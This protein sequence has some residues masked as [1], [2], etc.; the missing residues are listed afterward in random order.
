M[1]DAGFPNHPLLPCAVAYPA[2]LFYITVTVDSTPTRRRKCTVPIRIEGE[3]MSSFELGPAPYV[4]GLPLEALML[5]N[6]AKR[7]GIHAMLRAVGVLYN[8]IAF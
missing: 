6:L 8:S 4:R 3:T 5:Y 1:V 2:F 7:C